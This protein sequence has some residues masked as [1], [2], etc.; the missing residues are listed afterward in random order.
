MINVLETT[1]YGK[2]KRLEG[3]RKV[4]ESRVAKI[5]DSI[6]K[7]GPQ[8]MPVLVNEKY[9]VIDGQGRLAAFSRLKLP[10]YYIVKPGLG[11]NDC[12]TMNINQTPWRLMDY[13]ECFAEQGN[14]SYIYLL[15][16]VDKYPRA[17]LNVLF[18]ALFKTSKATPRPIKSGNLF[19]SEEKYKSAIER[20]DYAYQAIE[21]YKN[22]Y[23]ALPGG[24][25]I[26]Q[27]FQVLVFCYDYPE[28]D[29]EKLINVLRESGHFMKSWKDVAT[30]FEQVES[31]YNYNAKA[32][33]T[34]LSN[35]FEDDKSRKHIKMEIT[36][37]NQGDE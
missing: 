17:N 16:L 5:I 19:I 33:R 25:S 7:I 22:N 20:L 8:P 35:L 10:I 14:Q 6:K 36:D 26:Q 23:S 34:R 12:I 18:T 37:D 9:E 30:C 27:L 11:I 21:I 31:I 13:I 3:N 24:S 15:D 29:K 32:K 28:V 1:D 2:F 4:G